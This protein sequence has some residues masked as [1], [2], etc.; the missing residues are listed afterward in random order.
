MAGFIHE[1]IQGVGGAVPLADGYLPAAYKVG[2]GW[3]GCCALPCC[4]RVGWRLTARTCLLAARSKM[5][6]DS[7][8]AADSSLQL[9]RDAG[10]VCI[11]DEVQTGFGRTG[12][13]YW[14][15]QN[16]VRRAVEFLGAE[17]D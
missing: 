13:A 1:T 8:P 7:C 17:I 11:A 15:F 14:G 4:G 9:I 16:Q 3:V 10:G 6:A 12:S 2:C 5:L